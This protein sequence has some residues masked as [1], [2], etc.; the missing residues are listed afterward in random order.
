MVQGGAATNTNATATFTEGTALSSSNGMIAIVR[1]RVDNKTTTDISMTTPSGWT[2]LGSPALSDNGT[3]QVGLWVFGKQG[4]G[5]TNSITVAGTTGHY[6]QITLSGYSLASPS[7]TFWGGYLTSAST[8]VTSR[9]INLA[10]AGAPNS[11]PVIGVGLSGTTGGSGFAFT[12]TAG[13]MMHS[14]GSA[15]QVNGYVAPVVG[16][17]AATSLVASWTSATIAAAAG[18]WITG[19]TP[20]ISGTAISLDN[21]V[22]VNVSGLTTDSGGTLSHTADTDVSIDEPISGVFFIQ[23]LDTDRT[24]VITSTD[25]GGATPRTTTVVVKAKDSGLERRIKASGAL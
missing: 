15:D 23:R 14:T 22:E 2:L 19:S 6:T 10:A 12:P 4:D 18:F 1:R 21:V 24:V 20:T 25:S 5:T 3:I 9:T 16:T 11:L 8:N 17:A 7:S 13:T